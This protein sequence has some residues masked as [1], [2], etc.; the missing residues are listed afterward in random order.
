MNNTSSDKTFG[1]D[2]FLSLLVDEGVTHLFGNP[3]TTELPIMHAL[4]DHTSLTYVLGLQ[5][6]V[7]VA[8][9]DGF[10]RAS[11]KL[12]ACNVHV[13]PGLGNALGAI[14]NANL[15]GSP[16]IITAGQQEQGHGLMEP[17]LY[18]P[19]VDMARPLVKWATEITRIE[20]V[21][22]IVRRAAKIA[23]APPT[24]PVFLS[25]PGDILNK[26]AALDLGR[27]TRVDAMTYPSDES[28]RRLSER[29]M[30][31][32][33]PVLLAG[34]E[35][36]RSDA[37]TE[38]AEL[39]EVL[40]APVYQQTVPH[41]AHFFSEHPAFMGALTRIQDQ[42]RSTLSPY[43]LM[44]C[45]GADVLQMSVW[46]ETDPLPPDLPIIQ[47]GL[48]DW[49][50]GKNYPAEMAL[51][52]DVKETLQKL[53]PQLKELQNTKRKTTNVAALEYF[54]QNNWSTHR[55]QR[56]QDISACA[57]ESS[58]DP[59]WLMMRIADCIPADAII[60]DEGLT[61][62]KNLL[63]FLPHRDRYSY[64]GMVS[65]GI[66]WGIA[67]AVGVQLAQPNRRVVAISGDGSAMY[68]PQ[69]LWTAA[70]LELP[71]LFLIFNNQGYRILKE[72]LLAFHGNDQYI[73]MNLR[74][75]SIDFT[76]LAT[77]F[78]MRAKKITETAQFEA[79]FKPAVISDAPCLFEI[80]L[81]PGP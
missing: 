1:R 26:S 70:H 53:I 76:G 52:S 49:E 78:G 54:T 39:A 63:H 60:V 2:A 3:G 17:L 74:E 30:A 61:T 57:D 75:P 80:M 33:Q 62:S 48:R 71:I 43:D 21:P 5:E 47:I 67:A 28:L 34:T 56:R 19:L 18:G 13:A 4:S 68:S 45:I 23:L 8:M 24:G 9:A 7:V 16:L 31:A 66:G 41:G 79:A 10:C 20:D 65:G 46:S 14:Y 81:Q 50:M 51:R 72:R 6:S 77:S 36:V 25:L 38:A 37:L 59:D 73:G 69:A 12:A 44:I 55:R 64:F 15:S 27:R 40:G 22:R 32:K 11:G 58:I 42:V 35:I 29:I